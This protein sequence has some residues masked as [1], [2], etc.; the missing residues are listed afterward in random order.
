MASSILMAPFDSKST[1][2]LRSALHFRY[3]IVIQSALGFPSLY[4]YYRSALAN[5]PFLYIYRI[6]ACSML[7]IAIDIINKV[8]E[9]V[10]IYHTM[11]NAP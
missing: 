3:S 4:Y 5:L 9:Y 7:L 8:Y 11:L 6:G 1:S 10:I 2:K